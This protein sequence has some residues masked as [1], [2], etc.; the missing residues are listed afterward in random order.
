MPFSTLFRI[1]I[2]INFTVRGK[3]ILLVFSSILSLFILSIVS[4]WGINSVGKEGREIRENYLTSIVNLSKATEQLYLLV[5]EGKNHITSPNEA[6][7][8]NLEND[9]RESEANARKYLEA[10]KETLDAGEETE[11]FNQFT[12]AFTKYMVIHER[13]R[14][15][16]ASNDD[17]I[18]AEISGTE[19]AQAFSEMQQLL[20]KML[21][22]NVTGADIASS[23]ADTNLTATLWS[24]I[25]ISATAI[26]L[27][28]LTSA[29]GF[30]PVL[31]RIREIEN[32]MNEIS[33]GEGDLRSRLNDTSK[34]EIGQLSSSFNRFV[35][36][37]QK[38][39]VEVS[40]STDQLATSASQLKSTSSSITKVSHDQQEDVIQA[41]S[42]IE[43]INTTVL[44]ISDNA[45]TASTAATEARDETNRG[46]QV[47]E[48]T[49][50]SIN[51]LASDVTKVSSIIKTLE[52]DSDNIGKIL[53]V[54]RSIADQTNLLALNAAIEAARAGEQGRGFAVVADEV[55]T[56]AGRTQASTQEI[57]QMI[58]QLQQGTE[59]A[60]SAMNKSQ[61]QTQEVVSLA[62]EAGKALD[63]ITSSVAA[64]TDMN[65]QIA[66]S[67]EEQSAVSREIKKNM[68]N[69]NSA[70]AQMTSE[71]SQSNTA[72]EKLALMAN[73]LQGLVRRFKF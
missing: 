44:Q 22:N 30:L 53:D 61:A 27:I 52:Q 54:I 32:N 55:R 68:D 25:I 67:S 69:V 36:Q 1:K 58:E 11:L 4:L 34:D 8:L 19:G 59:S 6:V 10:F 33:E 16:S 41:T 38:L 14:V 26:V 12:K 63:K 37:I 21:Q 20:E 49:I 40:S 62:Q 71:M 42:A 17:V 70:S 73:N 45:S 31:K 72:A 18:A 64:I 48:Q 46:Q 29:L 24:T 60:S 9:M 43:E 35:S 3:V 65:Y 39:V 15:L 28:V 66:A 57:Q 5:I 7:M 47:V 13:V 2:M 23:H 50:H 51:Q 56:L